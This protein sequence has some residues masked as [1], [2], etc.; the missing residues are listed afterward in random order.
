[1]GRHITPPRHDIDPDKKEDAWHLSWA[2][3]IYSQDINGFSPIYSRR[4]DFATLRKYSN[5]EQDQ[6]KY[7][8]ILIGKK[9]KGESKR[10]GYMNVNWEI[11]SIAP[12]FKNVVLN[13]FEEVDY[14]IMADAVD[15]NSITEKEDMKWDLWFEKEYSE[16]IS[17]ISAVTETQMPA[18]S[19]LPKSKEELELYGAMGGFKLNNEVAVEKL[20]DF[21]DDVSN[22]EE[23]SRRVR[24]DFYVLNIGAV[25]DYVE[26]DTQQVRYKRLDPARL[27]ILGGGETN[28]FENATAFGYYVNYSIADI[29][30]A[31]G[32]EED[33]LM[34]IATQYNGKYT[35]T[36]RDFS[37]F[38]NEE[39]ENKFAYD[40]IVV[41]V[42]ECEFVSVD[43]RYRTKRKTKYGDTLNF[44][45]K[46]GKVHN[47]E[48]RQTSKIDIKVWRKV[49]WIVGTDHVF[50]WGLQN[51]IPRPILN[52]KEAYSSFHVYQVKGKSIQ[53]QI[54]PIL[55]AL[56]LTWL[57]YQNLKATGKFSGVSI[58]FSSIQNLS[59]GGKKLSPLDVL[60]IYTQQNTLLYKSTT[61]AGQFYSGGKP[62]DA[63]PG[64]IA[65]D[66]AALINW[67]KTDLDLLREVT[68]INQVM[69][70]SDPNP[71][72]GLGQ[73]QMAMTSAS[74]SLKTIIYAWKSL[75]GNMMR[76]AALRLQI[77]AKND[78]GDKMYSDIIGRESWRAFKIGA[79]KPMASY[80]I[81]L[82]PRL[83]QKEKQEI[84]IK[85]EEA[86]KGGKNGNAS[87]TMSEYFAVKRM[88]ESGTSIKY[89]QVFLADRERIKNERELQLQRE[90]MQI[91]SDNAIKQEKAKEETTIN[92]YKIKTDDDIRKIRAT[93]EEKRKTV[94]AKI[95]AEIRLPPKPEKT[96][97]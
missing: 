12:K 83:T 25:R 46:F 50:D 47:D 33:E 64:N 7:M 89:I 73:S 97:I 15:E 8:D 44:P 42:V 68:G 5:A 28:N 65:S 37:F 80:G 86:I 48:T 30:L 27:I 76:N 10:K 32:L 60:K 41:P 63:I 9:Q 84:E 31:S 1:M 53:A 67:F 20:L 3:Y 87:I 59:L 11:F 51:D 70:A 2:K 96:Q 66:T 34:S 36:Y 90:N 6:E 26:P 88:I 71:E 91:N 49:S 29:R 58:E 56:Q 69:A 17:I 94:V 81:K 77:V 38:H 52:P 61:H 16:L 22:K 78:A 19:F 40:D 75:Y 57:K 82:N 43:T 13:F 93:E 4:D 14:E 92:L 35:N 54:N 24:E 21:V 45:E 62:V 85:L 23:V 39:D 72:V 79:S 55:D 74:N 18:P 95:E